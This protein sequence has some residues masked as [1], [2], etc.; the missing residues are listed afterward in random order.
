MAEALASGA[1]DADG[2][3][4]AAR[5]RALAARARQPAVAM[6]RRAARGS[7]TRP[8]PAALN[9]RQRDRSSSTRPAGPSTTTSA[10][11]TSASGVSAPRTATL[12]AWTPSAD[13]SVERPEGLEVRDVVPRVEDGPQLVFAGRDARPRSPSAGGRTAR[14]RAPS[15]P[16]RGARPPTRPRR[17]AARRATPIARASRVGRLPVV[18]GDRHALVLDPG[19]GHDGRRRLDARHD[20]RHQVGRVVLEP[21]Q[22]DVDEVR[23]VD[24][25]PRP[26]RSVGRSRSRRGGTARA[27]RTST[28]LAPST[29]RASSGRATISESVPSKSRRMPADVRV[30]AQRIQIGRRVRV[31]QP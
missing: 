21:V 1:G 5:A 24:E 28:S 2:R 4:D 16:R 29:G 6:G 18:H 19:L 8:P 11:R 10:A 20:R 27:S 7:R 15:C 30:F 25:R 17:V 9:P 23:N 22:T 12:H 26:P 3:A 31:S 14:A 13:R